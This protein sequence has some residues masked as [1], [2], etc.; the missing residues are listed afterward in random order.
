ML[1]AILSYFDVLAGPRLFYNFPDIPDYIQLDHIP[2]LM[3]FY[4]H[5]FFIHEFGDLKTSNL[6]FTIPNPKT[7]GKELVMMISIVIFE[8]KYN[9]TDLHDALEVFIQ[10]FISIKDIFEGIPGNGNLIKNSNFNEKT[11]LIKDLVE[12]FYESLPIER[13]TIKLRETRILI[14]G[15]SKAGITTLIQNLTQKFSDDDIGVEMNMP[16]A[17]LSNLTIFTYNFTQKKYFDG[18]LSIF[19]RKI[20]GL[21]FIMNSS[22]ISN[23]NE[24]RE[25]L[26]SINNFSETRGL[27]LLILLNKADNI[28]TEKTNIIEQLR[29]DQLK[30]NPYQYFEVNVL[31]KKGLNESFQWFFNELSNNLFKKSIKFFLT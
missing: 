11:K 12:L 26:H 2:L 28:S 14:Y 30:Y 17:L 9:L 5:G 6:I 15:L 8:E 7:R 31:N 13:S 1:I 29:F 24:V 22:N 27:P 3:D 21:I 4:D 10:K 23:I 18:V 16:K 19:L 20:D 25:E